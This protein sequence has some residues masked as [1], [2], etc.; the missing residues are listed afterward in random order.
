MNIDSPATTTHVRIRTRCTVATMILV[1]C[2]YYDDT[3]LTKKNHMHIHHD[4]CI[5]CGWLLTEISNHHFNYPRNLIKY[6]DASSF[7]SSN[8]IFQSV[9][10]FLLNMSKNSVTEIKF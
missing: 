7:F 2:Q 10:I 5:N 4:Q 9:D 1:E 3:A 6:R 8:I